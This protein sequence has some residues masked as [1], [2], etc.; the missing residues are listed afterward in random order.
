MRQSDRQPGGTD[1]PMPQQS[2][3]DEHRVLSSRAH[4]LRIGDRQ[5]DPG[6]VGD[7][8]EAG[9]EAADQPADAAARPGGVFRP[10]QAIR[11]GAVE[12]GMLQIVTHAQGQTAR[13]LPT[14]GVTVGIGGRQL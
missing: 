10:E 13:L 5:P 4:R 11:N 14:G 7:L 2:A 9:A 1:E 8:G 6:F 3:I 12:T